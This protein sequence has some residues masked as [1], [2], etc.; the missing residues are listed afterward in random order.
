Q[1]ISVPSG[2]RVHWLSRDD[3]DAR[4]GELAPA[5][6]TAAELPQQGSDTYAF[7]VGESSMVTSLRRHLVDE[8]AVP[9]ENIAFG[10]Y[11]R[12]GTA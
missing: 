3:P 8:R 11:W 6:A 12:Y 10:G 4:P 7:V 2:V 5:T 9:K 1:E